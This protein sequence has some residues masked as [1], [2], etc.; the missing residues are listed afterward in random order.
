M[1]PTFANVM[2]TLANAHRMKQTVVL[3]SAA[4][5]EPLLPC[6]R[7][8]M[9]AHMPT[10]CLAIPLFVPL[11]HDLHAQSVLAACPHTYT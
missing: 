10:S 6:H 8:F 2:G 4:A 5:H 1:L 7:D 11:P 3:S 9:L